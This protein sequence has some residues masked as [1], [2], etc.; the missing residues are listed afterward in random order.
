MKVLCL[1]AIALGAALFGG[2][3][4]EG[5]RKVDVMAADEG[6]TDGALESADIVRMASEMARSIV[7][8]DE[9]MSRTN[10][11]RAIVVLDRIENQTSLRDLAVSDVSLR[12]M[13]VELNRHATDRV[14]FVVRRFT[15]GRLREQR[16]DYDYEPIPGMDVSKRKK[17]DYALKGVFYDHK[18]KKGT[19]HLCTFQLINLVTGDMRWEDSYEVKRRAD[20]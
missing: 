13:R 4:K 18:E 7:R 2:C 19:Y 3:V 11:D 12:K 5:V 10:E 9:I 20:R 1:V 17:P 16:D 15:Y 8:S 14:V 6:F